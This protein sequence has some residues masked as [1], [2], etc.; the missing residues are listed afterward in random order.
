MNE[1]IGQIEAEKYLLIDRLK[2]AE[3]KF[4]NMKLQK[5][6]YEQLYK[7]YKQELE[8]ILASRSFK[9][10]KK[11]SNMRA[12]V[13]PPNSKRTEFVKKVLRKMSRSGSALKPNRP[14]RRKYEQLTIPA[15]LQPQVSIIIPVYNHFDY[16]YDCIN[17]IIR[18]TKEIEYEIILADDNSTDQ[19]KRAG[20]FFQNAVIVRNKENLGFL[21]NCNN[22]AKY[23]KGEYIH[24]LNNDTMAQEGWLVPLIYLLDH[25]EDIGLAG[26]KLLCA[27]GTLQEAGGI[28]W[29]D[30]TGW[31]FGL[32]QDPEMPEY[33]YI[34]EVDYIS[35]ASIMIRKSLWQEIGGF[36]E[37]YAPAYF[38]DSDLAFEVRKH[39]FKVVYQPMSKI[40]HFE[41]ISNGVDE[42]SGIKSYQAINR[43]K[44]IEKWKNLM[45]TEHFNNGEN[46]FQ[47]RDRSAHKKTILVVDHY[48]PFFDQDAGSRAVFGYLNMFLDMGFNVKFIGDNYFKHE[49]Y[50]TVLEQLGIEV[51]YGPKYSTENWKDWVLENQKYLDYVM[52]S[53]P[54]YF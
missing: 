47:A 1:K 31:N 15:F 51:L 26:S 3:E 45:Q 8:N 9:L 30:A 41:G 24:F 2:Y 20:Y 34:K 21:L 7:D 50:T 18:N 39:G 54:P 37:R 46:V 38:E 42:N 19:T 43:S 32:G 28:I 11:L 35:G 36:D 25:H 12:K 23:A 48:V 6:Q 27:D 4:D 33:N 52:L 29:N 40:V 5:E 44:F 22:A 16:T 17:S 14:R 49:P 53:P 10:V 13:L